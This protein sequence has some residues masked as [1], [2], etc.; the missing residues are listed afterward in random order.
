LGLAGGLLHRDTAGDH[1]DQPRRPFDVGG[2]GRDRAYLLLPFPVELGE[3]GR[4]VAVV[5][6]RGGGVDL[7]QADPTT[8]VV[9][10][11]TIT[12]DPTN[13][14]TTSIA[15]T[16]HRY[17]DGPGYVIDGTES[18]QNNGTSNPLHETVTWFENLTQSG[19]HTGTKVTSANGFTLGSSLLLSNN[20]QATGTMTTTID[21]R[22]YTQPANST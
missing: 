22:T 19:R 21:G 15:V 13:A 17:S 2:A 16:Y 11:V 3:A 5:T 14:F 9:P 6:C 4:D 20:F 12:H 18:V 8:G 1:R 7:E 10:T